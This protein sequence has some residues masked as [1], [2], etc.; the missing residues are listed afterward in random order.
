VFSAYID[1]ALKNVAALP[2]QYSAIRQDA[3]DKP[4]IEAIADFRSEHLWKHPPFAPRAVA[5]APAEPVQNRLGL[6]IVHWL[7]AAFAMRP[8]S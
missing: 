8:D 7:K 2:A 6:W 5:L 3:S 1:G 4:L